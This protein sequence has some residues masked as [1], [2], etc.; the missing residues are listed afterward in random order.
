MKRID[1]KIKEI[2]K[3]EKVNR[4]TYYVILA[5]LAGFLYYASTT[6][7]QIQQKDAEISELQV[8]NSKAYKELDSL[9]QH[10]QKLYED[11]KNS[12]DPTEYWEYTK[13]E[14][15]V[16]GYI[17]Y[18]TNVWGIKTD[19]IEGALKKLNDLVHDDLH[20]VSG[21]LYVGLDTNNKP[22]ESAGQV[23][24][25]WRDGKLATT[26]IKKSLPQV[27]DIVKYVGSVNRKTYK[28]HSL[29]NTNGSGWRPDMKAL[30]TK[31]QPDGSEVK[32]KIKYN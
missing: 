17:D 28:N 22:Y 2:E 30:V 25:V 13:E 14:N 8:K 27:N 12:L 26:D 3:K 11:L 10:T 7:K 29:T 6:R 24:V 9:N 19:N 23:E 21:W 4:V 15:T 32:I 1:D 5:L 31:V 16:G 18:I 20:V